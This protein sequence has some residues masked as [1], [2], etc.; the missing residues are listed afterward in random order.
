MNAGPS[1]V[2]SSC[3]FSFLELMGFEEE[4]G[5]AVTTVLGTM[6]VAAA[7]PRVFDLLASLFERDLSTQCT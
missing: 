5:E 3:L 4:A 1:E 2:S 7:F 6:K